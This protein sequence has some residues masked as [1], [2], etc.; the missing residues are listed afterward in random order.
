MKRFKAEL[1]E[2]RHNYKTLFKCYNN[3]RGK[4]E[5][6]GQKVNPGF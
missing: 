6:M 1:K 2:R 3:Y 5:V 4:N